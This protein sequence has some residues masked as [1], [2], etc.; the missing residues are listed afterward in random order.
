MTDLSIFQLILLKVFSFTF[1]SSSS[2]GR[3]IARTCGAIIVIIIYV[4]FS[5]THCDHFQ[6]IRYVISERFFTISICFRSIE[7]SLLDAL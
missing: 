2:G 6:S 1:Y 5:L 7:T 3:G 4:L